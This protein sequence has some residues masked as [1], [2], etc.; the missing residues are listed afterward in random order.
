MI[1]KSCFG[2][3][4]LISLICIGCGKPPEKPIEKTVTPVIFECENFI[5]NIGTVRLENKSDASNLKCV[6]LG[7]DSNI[8]A[9]GIGD[10]LIYNIELNDE[11]SSGVLEINYTDDVGG[12]I[13][14]VYCDSLNI[15]CFRTETTGGWNNFVLDTQKI[16]LGHLVKGSHV[17]KFEMT[18]GGSWGVLLD[19]FKI[20]N[21]KQQLMQVCTYNYIKSLINNNT[22]LVR[23]ALYDGN[24]TTIYKNALS[25]MVFM[26]QNDMKSA[27]NIFDFFNSKYVP[28]TFMGFNK[29]WDAGT[30]SELAP[31]YWV[32]DNSFLLLALNYYK[33]KTGSYGK[34]EDMVTGLVDWLV[35]KSSD[36]IIA[37]GL[38]NMY[39]ALKPFK[40]SYP[41]M[42]MILEKLKTG[43]YANS[44][45]PNV[46]DHTE[47][48]ALCFA[49]TSGFDYISNF[50]K[51]ETWNYNGKS[52]NLLSAFS[53]DNYSN[54]EISIQ[55]LL[56]WK[57]MKKNIT[58][59]LSYLDNE[60]DKIWLLSGSGPEIAFTGLPYYLSSDTNHGWNG[61]YDEP[62][63]D[64]S[65]YILFY[66]WGFNP[67]DFN[68]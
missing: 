47:R 65:C 17:I 53:A 68:A 23:S 43:F 9:E 16:S 6:H 34:Y 55:I 10:A 29:S 41:G 66:Y 1:K 7:P 50:M 15:G 58:A 46:L 56:A 57:I 13:I 38:A 42:D 14:H 64:T 11:F 2:L 18:E 27:E 19:C 54:V 32:G 51:N 37:E 3:F 35:L 61:C 40:N 28:S 63:V 26:H 67:M 4:L 44:V 30:G 48:A 39:S 24:F 5:E 33:S 49:D 36:S 12:N 8:E 31:D 60:I 45:F 25:A 20:F 52:V 59:D 22:G 62:I 21:L